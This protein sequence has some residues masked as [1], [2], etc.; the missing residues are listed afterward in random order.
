MKNVK[1]VVICSLMLGAS[2]CASDRD[3]IP[4]IIE[5][6][7]VNFEYPCNKKVNGYRAGIN[8]ALKLVPSEVGFYN[9]DMNQYVQSLEK[10]FPNGSC[11][12]TRCIGKRDWNAKTDD[13]E[14]ETQDCSFD[15]QCEHI[16]QDAVM[17]KKI[18]DNLG[19]TETF[20]NKRDQAVRSKDFY[21]TIACFGLNCL[22]RRADLPKLAP[23]LLAQ[24][25]SD[26]RALEYVQV[27]NHIP[28]YYNFESARNQFVEH[29]YSQKVDNKDN[30][31][32]K[33]KL[34]EAYSELRNKV[35]MNHQ[36]QA[37]NQ[38]KRFY[39]G[40]IAITLTT[41]GLGGY[42]WTAKK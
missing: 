9:D 1:L 11:L 14:V 20:M 39:Q 24:K 19:S 12:R 4:W 36:T 25:V 18:S 15:Q 34:D 35:L 41:V 27:K 32:T 26:V 22:G 7:I 37:L 13:R 10:E 5:Y 33:K 28:N 30:K 2:I 8:P 38:E 3:A 40:V 6:D 17:Q 29:M 16:L 23:K 31:F 42:L 21:Q